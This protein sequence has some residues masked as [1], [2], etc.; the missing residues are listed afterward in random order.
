MAYWFGLKTF[1]VPFSLYLLL[2]GKEPL[3]PLMVT[4]V[5]DPI[6]DYDDSRV[7][8]QVLHD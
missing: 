5:L 8:A 4:N 7:L 2:Y 6:I 3:S 1:L